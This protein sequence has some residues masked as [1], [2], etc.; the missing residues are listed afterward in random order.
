[1]GFAAVR[2]HNSDTGGKHVLVAM[3]RGSKLQIYH[4]CFPSKAFFQY[5]L[6]HLLC[7]GFYAHCEDPIT[8]SWVVSLTGLMPLQLR[9]GDSVFRST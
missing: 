5:T 6:N 2:E 1:M 7:S 3:G 8:Q 9:Y 4:P